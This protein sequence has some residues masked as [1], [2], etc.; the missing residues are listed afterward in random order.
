MKNNKCVCVCVY[1][2]PESL[3]Y[4]AEINRTLELKYT[5]IKSFKNKKTDT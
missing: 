5:S 2:I 3:C 4:T 1:L